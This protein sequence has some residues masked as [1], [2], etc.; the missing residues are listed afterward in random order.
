MKKRKL[1]FLFLIFLVTISTLSI[2]SAA[3]IEISP[4]SPGGIWEAIETA[5]NGDIIYLKDGEYTGY[6]NVEINVNRI[7]LFKVKVKM[8]L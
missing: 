1:L 7:L 3:S 8:L 2:V 5:N 4:T 6:Y